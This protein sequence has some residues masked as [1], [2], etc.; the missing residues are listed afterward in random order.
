MP[1]P[2]TCRAVRCWDKVQA[3]LQHCRFTAGPDLESVDIAAIQKELDRQGV[4]YE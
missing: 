2:V 1:R 3:S 4:R